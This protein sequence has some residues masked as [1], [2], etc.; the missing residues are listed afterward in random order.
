MTASIATRDGIR[1]VR[2]N[3]SV[4]EPMCRFDRVGLDLV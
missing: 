2:A 4:A 1:P 3:G